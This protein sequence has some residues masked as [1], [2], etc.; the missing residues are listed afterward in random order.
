MKKIPTCPSIQ[1]GDSPERRMRHARVGAE[2]ER[3]SAYSHEA[4]QG[5]RSLHNGQGTAVV[6]VATKCVATVCIN[7]LHMYIVLLM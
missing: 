7:L 6:P 1:D 5:T 3:T 4:L 2:H